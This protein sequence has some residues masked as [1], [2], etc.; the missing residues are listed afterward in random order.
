MGSQ[1]RYPRPTQR[2]LMALEALSPTELAASFDAEHRLLTLQNT[3]SERAISRK[4]S[5]LLK[6]APA[7][8]VLSFARLLLFTYG[9]RW[10]AYELITSHRAAYHC[11]SEDELEQLG[12]G[13]DSWWATDSFARTL[14]GPL[15]RDGLIGDALIIR[16]AGYPDLW[17]RRAA[18]VSTV[19]FNVRSLG[20]KGDTTRT[21][22]ICRLLAADHTDM[23]VKALSWALRELVYFD[24]QA[25]QRFLE[26]YDPV[27]AGRVKREAGNKLRT[28]LKNPRLDTHE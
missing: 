6:Q 23:V 4:Y 3:K 28:G 12:Q 11:L 15:W 27:L 13:I 22:L 24:A 26:E 20:G 14:S 21:L 17:W 2:G 1:Y 18:L 10:Q 16:W 9:H 25:V 5:A 7:E 8:D 19:A